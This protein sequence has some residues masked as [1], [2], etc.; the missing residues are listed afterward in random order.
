MSSHLPLAQ[1]LAQI[2]A[3]GEILD[4]GVDLGLERLV[5]VDEQL[6]ATHVPRLV[7]VPHL[8]H[9]R[10]HPHH[11]VT[12]HVEEP[13]E[14]RHVGEVAPA[15]IGEAL[16]V[17]PLGQHLLL[18]VP[19]LLGP[20]ARVQTVQLGRLLLHLRHLG[21]ERAQLVLLNF[22]KDI[23]QMQMNFTNKFYKWK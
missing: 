21:A 14:V 13:V 9:L 20:L 22:Y 8:P 11:E 17:G 18:L 1:V 19:D 23:L 6:D 15:H 7:L 16:Q 4:T 12:R 2:Q 5:V 3:D 10:L